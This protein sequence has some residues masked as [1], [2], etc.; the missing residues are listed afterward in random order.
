LGKHTKCTAK[1]KRHAGQLSCKRAKALKNKT[2]KRQ[3]PKRRRLQ[4]IQAQNEK[5][6]RPKNKATQ[7]CYG[8]KM[9]C[10]KAMV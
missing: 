9:D 8:K 6:L 5:R 3:R 4:K 7:K 1:R 2:A 10:K